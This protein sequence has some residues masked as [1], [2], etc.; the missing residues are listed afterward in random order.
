MLTDN[1]GGAG[2]TTAA[3][4]CCSDPVTTA[5]AGWPPFAAFTARVK[6]AYK[7]A[8]HTRITARHTGQGQHLPSAAN[9]LGVLR[10]LSLPLRQGLRF[11]AL[12]HDTALNVGEALQT[13]SPF[14][15]KHLITGA[16]N[17]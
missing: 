8:T 15:S 7:I 5:F 4:A 1:F 12:R 6:K 9:P 11:A 3:S 16:K 17:S 13:S 10:S 14:A 2:A